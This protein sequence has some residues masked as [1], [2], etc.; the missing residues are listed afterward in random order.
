MGFIDS[1]KR[2]EKICSEMYGDNHGLS[3]YIEEMISYSNGYYHVSVW[4]EDLRHLKHYR[5]IRNQIVH[6]PDCTEENMCNSYDIQWLDD[7]YSRIISGND[8]L[9]LYRK[10]KSQRRSQKTKE[11]Y[12]SNQIMSPDDLLALYHKVER[13]RRVKNSKETY[14]SNQSSYSTQ[15]HS[16]KSSKRAEWLIVL[17]GLMF[18]VVVVFLFIIYCKSHL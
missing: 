7:F 15:K 5:W 12:S 1:Y 6:E 2:L 11:T 16:K 4:N 18:L 10:V 8:P 13:K 14:S 17:M 9:A 3:I